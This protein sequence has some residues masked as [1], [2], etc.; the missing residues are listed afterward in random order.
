MEE[1]EESA[2]VRRLSERGPAIPPA[3]IGMGSALEAED[4]NRIALSFADIH[5]GSEGGQ[6]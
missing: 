6:L 5:D 4:E 3:G 1:L 2:P